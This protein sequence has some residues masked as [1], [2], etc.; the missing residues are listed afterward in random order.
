M[1]A[2]D[3]MGTTHNAPRVSD[4]RRRAF[5]SRAGRIMAGVLGVVVA[6]A[7]IAS[8]V[9]P[10]FDRDASEALRFRRWLEEHGELVEQFEIYSHDFNWYD[11][12]VRARYVPAMGIDVSA[13]PRLVLD[14]GIFVVER[15]PEVEMTHIRDGVLGEGHDGWLEH[16][17]YARDRYNAWDVRPA[18]DP[19]EP[20]GVIA[21][22]ARTDASD[23]SGDTGFQIEIGT[24]SGLDPGSS[25]PVV[26]WAFEPLPG[27]T[28]DDRRVLGVGLS[29]GAF[30]LLVIDDAGGDGQTPVLSLRLYRSRDLHTVEPD[31]NP[32]FGESQAELAVDAESDFAVR[33]LAA[34]TYE[35]GRLFTELPVEIDDEPGIFSPVGLADPLELEP[36]A[37]TAGALLGTFPDGEDY[38]T[39]LAGVHYDPPDGELPVSVDE[40]SAGVQYATLGFASDSIFLGA[41]RSRLESY[42][43][44]SLGNPRI[45]QSIG[46]VHYIA[47]LPSNYVDAA[48]SAEAFDDDAFTSY[49]SHAQP[50]RGAFGEE[51][52]RISVYAVPSARL[53]E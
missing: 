28:A 42:R 11:E 10:P 37:G 12:S 31:L 5:V 49:F 13:A 8:C 51:L 34:G 4:K 38:R 43:F 6:A 26:E 16:F 50:V 52:V 27:I 39:A 25:E 44:G 23:G 48:T 15:F 2:R 33:A 40:V 32:P 47:S 21:F 7:G 45:R 53:E 18:M 3:V 14:N 46:S 35:V 20:G 9:Y 29:T 24:V 22:Y 41:D 36:D 17:R 1:M 19:D 30:S